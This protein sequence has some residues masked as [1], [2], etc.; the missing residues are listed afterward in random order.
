M[1]TTLLIDTVP[2]CVYE[3]RLKVLK[4]VSTNIMP[5]GIAFALLM[6]LRRS[7]LAFYNSRY[8]L[9]CGLQ[10]PSILIASADSIFCNSNELTHTF[11]TLLIYSDHRRKHQRS[12]GNGLFFV[13]RSKNI[14][15]SIFIL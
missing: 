14:K 11:V 7:T 4:G 5:F 9:I 10:M 8:V 1:A 12:Q 13:F 6:L 3:S 15:M 2:S